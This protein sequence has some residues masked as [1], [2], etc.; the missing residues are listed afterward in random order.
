MA[1][2]LGWGGDALL[3]SYF[4]AGGADARSYQYNFR[5]GERAEGGNLLR[6]ADEAADS[7]FEAH[8]GQ[9]LYLSG[10]LA[11]DADGGELGRVHAGENGYG[12]QLGR[13]AEAVESLV[14]GGKHGGAS[15]GVEGEHADAEGG[16]GTH[17]RGYGVGNVVELEVEK[18]G[19]AAGQKWFKDGGTCG[20]EKLQTYFEPEALALEL[21]DQ[22]FSSGGIGDI[23]R[24]DETLAGFVQRVGLAGGCE[25]R[26]QPLWDG[27]S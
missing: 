15:G 25:G 5:A 22:G 6:R 16:G 17:R 11:A 8:F 3:I 12:Q 19:V 27:H 26:M 10:G 9:E 13:V 14:G 7:S 1:E 23:E 4:R 2:G 24:Y 18:D 21:V 20:D